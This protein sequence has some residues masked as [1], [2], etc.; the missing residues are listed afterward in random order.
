MKIIVKCCLIIAA[1][2]VC[3][4]VY[5][6]L[7]PKGVDVIRHKSEAE[8]ITLEEAAKGEYVFVDARKKELFDKG[9]I[10]GA[11]NIEPEGAFG[12]LSRSGKIIV[13]CSG[14][15][16]SDAEK[17]ADSLTEAG[18]PKVFVLAEGYEAW[19]DRG[20]PVDSGGL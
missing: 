10:K 9:H 16:C 5:N 2:F 14:G 19:K 15:S 4:L 11:V 1:A 20:L 12:E 6:F 17:V 13:Y 3:G 18:F 8:Y 7:S